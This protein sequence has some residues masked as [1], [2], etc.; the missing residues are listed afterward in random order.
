MRADDAPKKSA[1]L[2]ERVVGLR[3]GESL[4]V[5]LAMLYF[6]F[7]LAGY[8]VLRPVRETL[9]LTGGPDKLPLLFTGS[10]VASWYPAAVFDPTAAAAQ[11]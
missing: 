6:F 7:L 3:P 11:V 2:L 1:N 4:S 8:F 5:V 10:L 9:G